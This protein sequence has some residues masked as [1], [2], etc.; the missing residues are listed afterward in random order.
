MY[1]TRRFWNFFCKIQN[2]SEEKP[3][4]IDD[5]RFH[6][7][8]GIRHIAE[9]ILYEAEFILYMTEFILYEAEFI[10]YFG[11]CGFFILETIDGA[12]SYVCG[13]K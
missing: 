4:W 9:F 1:G 5:I 13:V 12:T 8:S 6:Y 7:H 2:L 3:E 10:L 11:E